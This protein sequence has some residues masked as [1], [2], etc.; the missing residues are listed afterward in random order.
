MHVHMTNIPCEFVDLRDEIVLDDV[1][2]VLC[3]QELV[4]LG[5]EVFHL[6]PHA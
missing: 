3:G 1:E 4:V 2:G 5:D 6:L